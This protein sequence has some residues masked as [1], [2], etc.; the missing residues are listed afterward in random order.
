MNEFLEKLK[1]RKLW[2]MIAGVVT[3][4]ALLLGSDAENINVIAGALTT[5]ASLMTYIITE[6]KIDAARVANAVQPCELPEDEVDEDM[7]EEL[8][9]FEEMEEVED[10]SNN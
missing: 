2:A 4:I 10:G 7:Y 9:E 3:G 6:G 5:V 1:S 8:D